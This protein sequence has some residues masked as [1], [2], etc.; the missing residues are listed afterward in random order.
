MV[1]DSMQKAQTTNTSH[2]A[3]TYL[4]VYMQPNSASPATPRDLTTAYH[5]R[6]LQSSAHHPVPL[7]P[8]RSTFCF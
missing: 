1:V 2:Y 7:P 4:N 5:S 3:Y 6:R 8:S